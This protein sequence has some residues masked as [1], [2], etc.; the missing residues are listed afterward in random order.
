MDI[1]IDF[2]IA[3][4][5]LFILCGLRAV[6]AD[7]PGSSNGNI[8]KEENDTCAWLDPS[9]DYND[10]LVGQQLSSSK[11]TTLPPTAVT[12]SSSASTMT[13]PG[14]DLIDNDRMVS[15]AS[16]A[17]TDIISV[18]TET[19]ETSG[20]GPKRIASAMAEALAVDTVAVEVESA[21]PQAMAAAVKQMAG[22]PVAAAVAVDTPSA[23]EVMAS[24]PTA[25]DSNEA[26]QEATEEPITSSADLAL[27]EL[28]S[29]MKQAHMALSRLE[30]EVIRH[31]RRIA[32]LAV[33]ATA[34]KASLAGSSAAALEPAV[35]AATAA[36]FRSLGMDSSST[37]IAARQA[38]R[39]VLEQV[40]RGPPMALGQMDVGF[41]AAS[42]RSVNHTAAASAGV[43]QEDWFGRHFAVRAAAQLLSLPPSP[44]GVPEAEAAVLSEPSIA[45]PATI[46][47]A[48][49]YELPHPNAAASGGGA[50]QYIAAGDAAGVLYILSPVDGSVMA[51][52]SSG[53]DSAVTACSAFYVRRYESTV[54]TGHAGGQTC[55]FAVVLKEGDEDD[56]GEN[57]RADTHSKQQQRHHNSRAMRTG[58]YVVQ[59]LRLRH[60]VESMPGGSLPWAAVEE[61]AMFAGGSPAK[62]MMESAAETGGE[63]AA[64]VMGEATESQY[65]GPPAPIMH[66]LPYRL[67]NKVSGRRHVAVL[68]RAG[69]LRLERDNG[70]L[71]FWTRTNRTQLAARLVGTH[72]VMLSAYHA[73]LMNT[74]QPRPPRAYTC[75]HLN[76]SRLLAASFDSHRSF[77]GYGINGRGELL[78][79]VTPHEGGLA[80]C[81]VHRASQLP[82]LDA[83]WLSN[84]SNIHS[85]LLTPLRGY[86]LLTHGSQRVLF[87]V[88][89]VVRTAIPI[90]T[91]ASDEFIADVA[92]TVAPRPDSTACA[93]TTRPSG[94]T[95]DGLIGGVLPTPPVVAVGTG[96]QVVLLALPSTPTPSTAL[97]VFAAANDDTSYVMQEEEAQHPPPT[98]GLSELVGAGGA[99]SSS[100]APLLVLLDIRMP[101]PP[102]SAGA[103]K[104]WSQPM[105][106]VAM[107]L[108]GLYQ[109][110]RM[111]NRR[112]QRRSMPSASRVTRNRRMYG[113]GYGGS[114]YGDTAAAYMYGENAVPPQ[115]RSEL[116]R[117]RFDRSMS[118]TVTYED[119]DY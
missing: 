91:S 30:T 18:P 97:G 95:G 25:G 26:G 77:R 48:F 116:R 108:V 39:E 7:A 28:R 8:C 54:V 12:L 82:W 36:V 70:T 109:F 40:L 115:S 55:S 15:V 33:A 14:N 57:A 74:L 42:D 45:A 102:I 35:E 61:T 21:A 13:T 94:P 65:T 100:G 85:L 50:L 29:L 5:S 59:S 88:T 2:K 107:L 90:V 46:T 67:G 118:R 64:D 49:T 84:P 66:I 89:G 32:R 87:N 41:G 78:S 71:R 23:L 69:N 17:A 22:E 119:E 53:T 6:L 117:V 60:V 80:T 11:A 105:F 101:Q 37:S 44:Q 92:N 79:M 63:Q 4:L 68:D 98:S 58:K 62:K 20:N 93:R 52:L 73:T 96:S 104:I 99:S 110:W 51:V 76:G 56:A 19:A 24:E 1:E 113:A 72:V 86:L 34:P 31:E 114:A 47:C 27:E 10:N 75:H 43:A 3:I 103:S 112:N 83:G 111:S 38:L 106:L 81:K 16:S 9:S